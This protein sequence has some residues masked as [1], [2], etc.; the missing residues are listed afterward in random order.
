MSHRP[1]SSVKGLLFCSAAIVVAVL[2]SLS[3]SPGNSA[4]GVLPSA[5]AARGTANVSLAGLY[6][7]LGSATSMGSA[8]KN[9]PEASPVTAP[10]AVPPAAQLSNPNC[11]APYGWLKTQGPWI[12]EASNPSCKVRLAGV[13]WYGMQSTTFTFA[14]LDFR[15]Y[16]AILQ[17]IADLG[18]N[19][20]R[21]PITDQDVKYNSRIKIAPKWM[22]AQN[23]KII[24]LHLHPLALLK[25]VITAAGALHLMVILDNHFSA[26]RPASNVANDVGVR[27][28]VVRKNTD[29]T[30]VADGYSEKDWINDWLK[31][32]KIYKNTPT[33]I[34]YDL[35]NEPHT[36][37]SGTPWSLMDYLR[38]GATWGPCTPAHCGLKDS[39]LW[40][41]SSNWPAAAEKAGDA[42]Q[43]INP[44]LLLFVEGTQLYPDLK[45]KRG[46]ENY[47]WGSILKGVAVD[48][49]KFTLPNQ[50]VYSPHE[51]GP[52][53]C[54]GGSVGQF[55][56][57]TTYASYVKVLTANWAYIL[58]D[59]K[60]QAPIWIGEF[61]TCNSAQPHTRWTYAIKTA[62]QC[63]YGRQ[64]GSEGQWF[65]LFIKFLKLHPE[66]GW[67]YYPI[68]GTN[69]LNE[70]SSNSI[71][72]NKWTKPRLPSL[73]K[74]LRSIE[75]QPTN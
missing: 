31:I 14:G 28:S 18:F 35:R 75:A 66:I 21:I 6:Q 17:E 67:A 24:P 53:K 15:P 70:A 3:L 38:R 42:I 39:K 11:K 41:P 37:F 68:N 61:D 49:V 13:T 40:E 44:H 64:P 32:T 50:L 65:Q 26:N 2:M 19:S 55:S 72:S 20:I 69:V 43:K 48:P 54:C 12:V 73:M 71:L 47:W 4:G 59:P 10:A 74:A 60:V 29:T 62:N 45:N 33:V 56:S 5:A 36:E 34:G 9:T 57:K 22:K 8:S 25:K 58:T 30:W 46:A 1:V 16:T 51:W 27:K 63:V 7:L 23:P 52:W